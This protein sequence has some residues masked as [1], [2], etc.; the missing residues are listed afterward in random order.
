MV[1]RSPRSRDGQRD[2]Q[3]LGISLPPE[4]AQ[5]VKTEAARRNI[6]MRALFIEMWEGFKSKKPSRGGTTHGG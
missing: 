6:T 1:K 2:R 4:V 5:E 3:I